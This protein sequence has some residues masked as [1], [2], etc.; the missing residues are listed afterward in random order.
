MTHKRGKLSALFNKVFK[1]YASDKEKALAGKWYDQLDFNPGAVFNDLAEEERIRQEMRA[2]LHAHVHNRPRGRIKVI[3]LFWIRSVAAVFIFCM[4]SVFAYFQISRH[5]S[6]S[7]LIKVASGN[8]SI[9]RFKLPDGTNITL[10]LESSLSWDE[11]YSGQVRK[12]TLQGEAF[13][14]VK[15]DKNHPFIVVCKNIETKVLGTAFDIE[16]YPSEAQIK[17]SLVRGKV[18]ITDKDNGLNKATLVPGQMMD[19]SRSTGTLRVKKIA[20]E[21]IDAWMRGGLTFNDIPL[22]AAIERLSRRYKL[23]IKYDKEKLKDRTVTA[24]FDSV[25]WQEALRSILFMHDMN[26]VLANNTIY[27][28]DN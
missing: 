16:S 13:F 19:Y 21:N 27:I 14:D 22:T 12:V 8:H 5:K 15:K 2:N 10:N 28:S 17:V 1:G 3:P 7:G 23:H 11:T 9:K 24:S 6:N 26:Y 4:L 25:S 20:V 18:R